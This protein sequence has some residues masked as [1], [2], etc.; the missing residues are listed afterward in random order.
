LNAASTHFLHSRFK[1]LHSRFSTLD[2]TF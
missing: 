2:F 1:I